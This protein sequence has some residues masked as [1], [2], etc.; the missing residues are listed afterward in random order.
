MIPAEIGGVDALNQYLR[1]EG[2]QNFTALEV[3]PVGR[4]A[5]NIALHMVPQALWPNIIPTLRVLEELRAHF[6]LP[7]GVLSGYRSPAYNAAVGGEEASLH[8]SFNAIDFR[9]GHISPLVLARWLH[10]HP[11]T[12]QLGIGCYAGFVHC[13]SRGTLGR[14]APARWAGDGRKWWA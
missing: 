4:T 11:M 2:I 9:C 1:A 14:P 8:L 10:A 3:C 7:V 6:H 12:G 5:G 13:D